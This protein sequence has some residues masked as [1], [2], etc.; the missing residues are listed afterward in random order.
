M[1]VTDDRSISFLLILV[2]RQYRR[3]EK[4]THSDE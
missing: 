3:K 1:H 4:K 2:L